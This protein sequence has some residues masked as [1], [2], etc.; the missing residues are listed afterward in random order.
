[1]PSRVNGRAGRLSGAGKST[2]ASLLPRLYDVDA[3]AVRLSG[4]DVRDL[5]FATLRG[6][7]AW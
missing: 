7:S 3:G 6:P 5:D 4:V 2:I 1:V